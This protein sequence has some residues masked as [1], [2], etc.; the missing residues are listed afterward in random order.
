MADFVVDSIIELRYRK[1]RQLLFD[2]DSECLALLIGLL[3]RQ[4]HRTVVA[5]CFDCLSPVVSMFEARYP[6]DKRLSVC[7]EVSRSW[8]RG[9]VKMPVAKKY[10]LEA[11]SMAKEM[12]DK[13]YDLLA[14]SVGQGCSVIHSARHGLGLVFYELSAL[15]YLYGLDN[16]VGIISDKLDFYLERLRFWEAHVDDEVLDLKWAS[17]LLRDK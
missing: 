6:L 15:V 12:D 4:K 17:F 11:H 13:V 5:W 14:H 7:L 16:C 1:G 3:A 8:A 2:F 9:E 10:I